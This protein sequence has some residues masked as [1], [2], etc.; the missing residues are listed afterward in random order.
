MNNKGADQSAW[1]LRLVCAFVIRKTR[2]T[3]FFVLRPKY[4]YTS[5]LF[6]ATLE[7]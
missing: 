4:D 7:T 6:G 5:F 2:T 1:L 3:G